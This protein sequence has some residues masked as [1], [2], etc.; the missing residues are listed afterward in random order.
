[1]SNDT[2]RAVPNLIDAI[3]EGLEDRTNEPRDR[4]YVGD[5]RHAIDGA[6][7]KR[8]LFLTLMGADKEELTIGERLMFLWGDRIHEKVVDLMRDNLGDEWSIEDVEFRVDENL[9]KEI[10]GR[11]DIK[12]EGPSGE[13]VIVEVKTA[14]GNSFKHLEEEGAKDGHRIQLQSYERHEDADYGLVLYVDREGSNR[15]QV[16]M[17]E[18]DDEAVEDA[19]REVH[20]V[21]EVARDT[22]AL[23]QLSR[24]LQTAGDQTETRG[25]AKVQEGTLIAEEV[26]GHVSE[27]IP[28]V[29]DPDVRRK[30]N[31][32]P[33]AIYVSLPWPCRYCSYADVS[34]DTALDTEYREDY[35]D[36]KIVCYLETPTN[37]V[38]AILGVGPSKVEALEDI[39]I[40]GVDDVLNAGVDTLATA[41]GIGT[42]TA[43]SI[44][45]AARDLPEE[46]RLIRWNV[47][48]DKQEFFE[49]VI[50]Q[51]L[52]LN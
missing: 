36:D 21:L 39:G 32:G 34:C 37:D 47:E 17:V 2:E 11:L 50:F 26:E 45:E 46:P 23:K 51:E 33:D 27:D 25:G 8:Q 6:G 24:R 16:K 31:K 48:E 52:D 10:S 19:Y 44:L 30:E 20:R 49:T 40:D 5:L 43:K 22:K 4:L 1:M 14:R 28:D 9:P 3:E 29:L 12:L 15:P 42:S 35:R 41:D 38:G 13:T 18:R 7:C